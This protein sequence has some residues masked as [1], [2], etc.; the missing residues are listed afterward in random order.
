M[1]TTA[2]TTIAWG[3]SQYSFRMDTG[4]KAYLLVAPVNLPDILIVVL[5]GLENFLLGRLK[6]WSIQQDRT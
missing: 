6:V 3:H 2:T 1:L 4:Q 5:Q